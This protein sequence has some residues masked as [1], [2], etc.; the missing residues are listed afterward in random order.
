M[1]NTYRKLISLSCALA[2]LFSGVL[3]ALALAPADD[4]V[5]QPYEN[6][7]IVLDD[8]DVNDQ[9][10]DDDDN[11]DIDEDDDEN[12]DENDDENV[13]ENEDVD[14]DDEHDDG[15]DKDVDDER[16]DDDDEDV[17]D[18]HDDDDDEDVDDERDD[19]DDKDVDDER[20]DDDDKDVDDE[21]DDDDD[22]DVDDERDDDDDKDVDD[23]ER[24]DDD[25]KDV[26]D[27]KHDL[28]PTEP[29]TETTKL[30]V[31]PTEPETKPTEP[32]SKPTEPES[33]PTEP[34]SKPTEPESKPTE[35]ESKPT[36]PETKPTEPETK[37][38]LPSGVPIDLSGGRY[39]YIFGYEPIITTEVETDEE[40]NV[41]DITYTAEICM[42]PDDDVTREQTTTMLMRLIDQEMD[43]MDKVYPLTDNIAVHGGTWYER[44]FAY[45]ANNGAFDDV[46]TVELGPIT[47]GEVAKLVCFGLNLSEGKETS[48]TDIDDSEFKPYIEIVAAYGYMNGIDDDGTIFEPDRVMT[49]A[50]FCKMINNIMGREKMELKAADGTEITP[51]LYSIV[52]IS[53]HWAEETILKATSVYDD[54]GYVDIESRLFN[55]RNTLDQYAAQMMY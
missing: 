31:K 7:G 41:I 51:E 36:E 42:G 22:E 20:D 26:D 49:R 18:E 16:D 28:K 11:E 24:D 4:D 5:V 17:D 34:E 37:P 47:R 3:N 39:A 44:G 48:F 29:I 21:H 50:E 9:D 19:D 6:L 30:E 25:D 33:K 12:V 14:V 32:E 13:D 27:D 1:K 2:V 8:P 45:L 53:G 23:D 54:D 15:D 35:P 55:I 46:D 40:G 38:H 52:D 43:T 10:V